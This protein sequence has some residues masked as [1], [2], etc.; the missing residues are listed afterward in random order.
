MTF[1]PLVEERT[2]SGVVLPRSDS[3]DPWIVPRGQIEPVQYDRASNL[4]AYLV[5]DIFGIKKWEKRLLLESAARNPDITALAAVEGYNTGLGLV[6]P[7]LSPE[8]NKASG[9]RLD[10]LI[11]R[12]EDRIGMHEKADMGTVAHAATEPGFNGV[13]HP[14]VQPAVDAIHELTA[15]LEVI[16]TEV[17]VANDATR[18][19]GT[20]DH[21][22][23]IADQALARELGEHFTEKLGFTVDLTGALIGDKKTG[24]NCHIGEFEVQIGGT[25][26]HGEVYQGPPSH[27]E[28][29]GDTLVDQ[30]LTL[31]EYF[32]GPVNRTTGLLVHASTT[33]APKP[34]VLPLDLQRGHRLALQAAIVRDARNEMDKIGIPKKLDM[35]F[36]AGQVLSARLAELFEGPTEQ[37]QD[38]ATA[39]WRRFKHVWQ[40]KHSVA[41]KARLA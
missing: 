36:L 21:A 8:E 37:V 33:G 24:K 4:A 16:A 3:G 10:D 20:F 38:G 13:V 28:D 41:V 11:A 6:Q 18:S 9:K 25:Y 31:E 27:Q 39:L 12:L 32:G 15:A 5:K 40:D 35:D 17:F 14:L 2:A 19:A 30:R 29:Y 23:Y 7:V 1:D 22:Y 34:R 26:A